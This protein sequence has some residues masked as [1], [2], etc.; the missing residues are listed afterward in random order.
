[1]GRKRIDQK[2]ENLILHVLYEQDPGTSVG[3]F[4]DFFKLGG[5]RFD[6]NDKQR[7]LNIMGGHAGLLE[8]GLISGLSIRGNNAGQM[9]VDIRGIA[10]TVAGKK[11]VEDHGLSARAWILLKWLL[12][13]TA[14]GLIA[15]FSGGFLTKLGE[16]V[17]NKLFD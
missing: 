13:A 17:F 9:P 6:P 11:Y 10:L 16:A 5:S 3:L 2:Y 14:G 15:A 12:T 7:V 8:Q 4:E 1:M